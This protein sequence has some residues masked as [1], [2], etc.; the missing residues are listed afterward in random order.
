VEDS[1]VKDS[2][3]CPAPSPATAMVSI[4][5]VIS[6]TN[7]VIISSDIFVFGCGCRHCLPGGFR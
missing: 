3:P 5:D 4:T 1:A 7:I 2:A 6:V